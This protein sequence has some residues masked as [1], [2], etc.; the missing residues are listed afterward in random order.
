MAA[1]W[2]AACGDAGDCDNNEPLRAP[3]FIE[4]CDG[5]DNDCDGELDEGY[6]VGEACSV[7]GCGAEDFEVWAVADGDVP[8]VVYTGDAIRCSAVLGPDPERKAPYLVYIG[9]GNGLIYALDP[10][11]QRRSRAKTA[12][13]VSAA[14]QADHPAAHPESARTGDP[15]GPRPPGC[16]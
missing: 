11:G 16:G 1:G 5:L 2:A 15:R 9:G 7:G 6:P 10:D 12:V 3:G 8:A 4:V 13:H 14:A